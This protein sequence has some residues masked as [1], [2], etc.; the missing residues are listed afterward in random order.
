[1]AWRIAS[2]AVAALLIIAIGAAVAMIG[3]EEAKQAETSTSQE[4]DQTGETATTTTI[5]TTTTT[6]WISGTNT[7]TG[8][9]TAY[10][11]TGN[12]EATSQE[13]ATTTTTITT[14]IEEESSEETTTTTT[15]TTET[16][17]P[18]PI[19]TETGTSSQVA[20]VKKVII[21]KM[22]KA[23]KGWVEVREAAIHFDNR[24]GTLTVNLSIATPDPC[25][26]LK[27]SMNTVDNQAIIEIFADRDNTAM[28]IQMVKLHTVTLNAKAKEAPGEIKIVVHIGGVTEEI[29]IKLG[30]EDYFVAGDK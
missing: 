22:V 27:T 18:V 15:S 30:L 5:T 23:E 2:I 29:I 24:T 12:E 17:G 4:P 26:K 1:M 9:T 3:G 14:T 6:P 21:G 16:T 28:C 20:G 11:E 10:T 8:P 7:R 25:W 19:T 13:P